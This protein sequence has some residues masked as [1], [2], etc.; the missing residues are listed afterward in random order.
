M[1]LTAS[2]EYALMVIVLVNLDVQLKHLTIKDV[3]G[4]FAVQIRNAYQDLV[5]GIH[6]VTD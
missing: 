5:L 4:P 1:I 6:A 2:L 3:K